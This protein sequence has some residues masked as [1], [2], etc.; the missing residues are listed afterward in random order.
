MDPTIVAPNRAPL[1][2]MWVNRFTVF[3]Q[4]LASASVRYSRL[5]TRPVIGMCISASDR[6]GLPGPNLG[7]RQNRSRE[8]EACRIF[9][10]RKLIDE[11]LV[12]R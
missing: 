7:Y 4:V 3:V 5:H 6:A 10:T 9:P 2:D 12:S 11:W 8:E 1:L